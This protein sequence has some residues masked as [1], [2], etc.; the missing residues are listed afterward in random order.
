MTAKLQEETYFLNKPCLLLRQ[1]TER[2]EGLG[3]TACLSKLDMNLIKKFTNNYKSYKRKPIK[4]ISPSKIVVD[5]LE[6]LRK[7]K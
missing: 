3:E 1:T 2:K 7:E 6:K 5:E 4:L